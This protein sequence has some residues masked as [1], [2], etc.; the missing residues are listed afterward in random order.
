M[1]AA[2]VQ[3]TSTA[4]VQK[5]LATC[6]R[7]VAEARRR[8]A[9]LAVLPENFA[10]MGTGEREKLLEVAQQDLAGA[11]LAMAR[12]H[13][14][15]IVAGGTPTPAPDG[16]VFNTALVV[17]AGGEL[18]ASYRKIHLFDVKIPGGA[19][20]Q[21]SA[22][23]APGKDVVVC[24]TPIGKVGL[25]ICYDVR[26]PELYRALAAA[27]ARTVVVPAAFTLHT[28]KDHWQPLLRAR[29]IEDQVHVLAAAQFGRANEKRICWGH[30]MIVD[31]WGTIVA[32][33]PDRE[34]VIVAE[35]DDA[36]QDKVRA[37]LPVL[38]HRRL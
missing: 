20:F 21:E 17:N 24:D 5:N 29:A 1:I 36:Y 25:S 33:A 32:E 35:L 22:T 15:W 30:S 18:V 11:V 12:E 13:G 27:G 8:G 28:G 16:K 38:S 19:E 9:A 31:P 26:F 10:F 23:V 37:E 4:D 14:I 2:C 3:L 7:L 6:G 34:C